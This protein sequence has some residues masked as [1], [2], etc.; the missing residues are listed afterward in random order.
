MMGEKDLPDFE[1]FGGDEG[2]SKYTPFVKAPTHT[3][4]LQNLV[5]ELSASVVLD[6]SNIHQTS[7]G[8]LLESIPIPVLLI[9]ETCKINFVNHAWQ[10]VSVNYQRILGR[11][12]SSIFTRRSVAKAVNSIVEKAF[13][14]RS[15]LVANARSEVE[16]CRIYGRVHFRSPRMAGQ[17]LIILVEDLT[18]EKN[19]L[20]SRRNTRRPF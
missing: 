16:G 20:S 4:D 5:D 6:F 18:A 13:M 15:P 9:D 17:A 12:F 3:I 10:K 7:F 2:P 11:S 1:L 19:N 14:T 8:K